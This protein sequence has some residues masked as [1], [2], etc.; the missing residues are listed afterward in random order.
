M[1][2]PSVRKAGLVTGVG[3]GKLKYIIRSVQKDLEDAFQMFVRIKI[4]LDVPNK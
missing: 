3:D 1:K 2:C 4:V